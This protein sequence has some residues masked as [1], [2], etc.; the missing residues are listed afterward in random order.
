MRSL[1]LFALPFLLVQVS[2]FIMALPVDPTVEVSGAVPSIKIPVVE[3]AIV[4]PSDKQSLDSPDLED[5]DPTDAA[6]D[7]KPTVTAP[8]PGTARK[9]WNS[10]SSVPSRVYDQLPNVDYIDVELLTDFFKK[11]LST[12]KLGKG[13]NTDY[14]TKRDAKKNKEKEAADKPSKPEDHKKETS[15]LTKPSKKLDLDIEDQLPV[16]RSPRGSKSP[17]SAKKDEAPVDASEEEDE[18][19]LVALD[20]F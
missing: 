3:S 8:T 9:I 19:Q 5:L 18:P 13:L 15:K 11:A 10:I 4:V 12:A 2:N 14:K 16:V 20:A 7:K 1:P 17:R 6:S